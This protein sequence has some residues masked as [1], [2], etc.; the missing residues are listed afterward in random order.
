MRSFYTSYHS[1]SIPK[2]KLFRC[3]KFFS[4]LLTN[5]KQS[6]I[7]VRIGTAHDPVGEKYYP[8]LLTNAKGNAIMSAQG[9]SKTLQEKVLTTR[10]IDKRY[11]Q[12]YDVR[13]GAEK[14]R[15][16]KRTGK[17]ELCKGG[18]ANG[19]SPKGRALIINQVSAYNLVSTK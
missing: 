1:L 17:P 8:D 7:I 13:T 6:A 19:E 10:P 14:D 9:Q 2:T 4:T 11:R 3:S 15:I 16:G 12:C 5:Q 18:D